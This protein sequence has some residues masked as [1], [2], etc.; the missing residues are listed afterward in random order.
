MRK[1]YAAA[2]RYVKLCGLY[3]LYGGL[4]LLWLVLELANLTP[5]AR[6]VVGT[7]ELLARALDQI[8]KNSIRL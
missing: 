2:M 1:R 3:A 5:Q 6:G 7:G 8:R 4:A